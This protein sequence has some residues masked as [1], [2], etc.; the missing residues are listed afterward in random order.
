MPTIKPLGGQELLLLLVQ[1][2]LLLFVART[3][4]EVAKRFH[5]PSVVGELLAGVVLGPSLLGALAPHVFHTVFPSRPEQ[6]H[7][8][9]ALSWLGVLML[10]VLTGIETDLELIARKGK[11]ALGISLGGILLPFVSGVALGFV[12]P[13]SFVAR[14]DQRGVFALFVGTAMSISAI[15]V[16]AKVLMDMDLIRRDIGQITLAAGMID[17]TMGWILLSVVAGLAV[18]GVVDP[19]SVGKSIASVLIVLALSLT[20]GRRLVAALIRAVDN[21]IGGD[22]AKITTLILLALALGSLTQLLGLEAVLGAFIAGILVGRVRRFD[23]QVA[24]TFRVV[25]LGIFTPVFFAVSGLRVDL[26]QLIHPGVLLVAAIVLAVA[27]LGKFVGVYLGARLTRLG[28]WEALSLGAGMNARGAMEI[29]VATIGL[30][31]GILT[32]KMYSIILLTAIATSLMAPPLLRWTIGRVEMD[33]EERRR[34]QTEDLRRASFVGNL[35]RVLLLSSGDAASHLAA[36]LVGLMLR[37]EDVEV[38]TMQLEAAADPGDESAGADDQDLEQ[39]VGELSVESHNARTLTLP[40]D[41]RLDQDVLAE[42]E[43]GYDLVVIGTG[44]LRSSEHSLREPNGSGGTA[45]RRWLPRWATRPGTRPPAQPSAPGHEAGYPEQPQKGSPFQGPLFSELVD[46]LIH[47]APCPIFIVTT[48]HSS[49]DAL[50]AGADNAEQAGPGDPIDLP[51]VLLP[52]WGSHGVSWGAE[53]AFST[54]RRS[55]MEVDVLHWVSAPRRSL[56][57]GWDDAT[58][59]AVDI[60]QD[61]VG[62][63]AE[64]GE[65]LEARVHTEVGVAAVPEQAFIDHARRHPGLIVLES[66]RSPVRRRAFFG[67]E[68]DYLLRHAPCPV[69][70]ISAPQ[71]HHSASTT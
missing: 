55:E 22:M 40:D 44:A 39:V 36:R 28:H 27:I 25:A 19:A 29:I 33:E 7:L 5:L 42:V 23:H 8:L 51:R 45:L 12:I 61:L 14:A 2:G 35:K 37:G 54:A 6:V 30:S 50:Q 49:E 53:I 26:A 18:R 32:P 62:K 69:A 46:Q 71:A 24:D 9:E 1:F 47:L 58:R 64:F 70:L 65:Q 4:G 10:L 31:L 59:H 66:T 68:V 16:I 3:L 38:T 60:G 21:R 52:V 48:P 67:H 17:D 11:G 34:L 41:G 57:A 15:P 20:V 13:G 63:V 56:R 43:K